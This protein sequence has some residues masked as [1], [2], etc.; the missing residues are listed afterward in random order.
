MMPPE[1]CICHKDFI[2]DKGGL[3]YFVEDSDDI[4]F[5]KRFEEPGFTG[6]PSNAFW[7]CEKHYKK[8]SEL[9]NMTKKE[10]FKILNDIF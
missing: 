7:F 4:A 3:I 2:P 8:A 5:N 9:S 10:A 1:C 6:H